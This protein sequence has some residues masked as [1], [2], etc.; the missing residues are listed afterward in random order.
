M[1][2]HEGNFFFELFFLR[3][4]TF[5][6]RT[7]THNI[8]IFFHSFSKP[9][10]DGLREEKKYTRRRG[11]HRFT[12]IFFSHVG[13]SKILKKMT[14][15]VCVYIRCVCGERSKKRDVKM[16]KKATTAMKNNFFSFRLTIHWV[17]SE[18]E[19]V[20]WMHVWLRRKSW[21]MFNAHKLRAIVGDIVV[22]LLS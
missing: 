18:R 1:A 20:E 7:H 4:H 19:S 10:R 3:T 15:F 2:I 16:W 5:F 17:F 8:I 21:R 22:F 13:Y 12:F 6:L 9:E 11:N 14:V